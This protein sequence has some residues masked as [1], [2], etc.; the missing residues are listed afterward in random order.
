MFPASASFFELS[1]LGVFRMPG[2]ALLAVATV[3]LQ[4]HDL[5]SIL[6]NIITAIA[7]YCTLR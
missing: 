7:R 4:R 6:G 5:P 2:L 3:E 1:A